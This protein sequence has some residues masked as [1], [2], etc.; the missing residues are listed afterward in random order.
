M[1]EKGTDGDWYIV[2]E[3]ECDGEDSLEELFE[4][5]TDSDVS[6]LLDDSEQK[7]GN[8]LQL[9]QQQEAAAS[10]QLDT[11]LKRKYLGTPEQE[12]D[13]ANLS[14]RLSAVEISPKGSAAKKRLFGPLNDSGIDTPDEA[15]CASGSQVEPP[16]ADVRE[17]L[18]SSNRVAA[19]LCKF[20]GLLDCSFK[21]L[22]RSYQSSKT[23]GTNWVIFV[24][25]PYPSQVEGAKKIVG[26]M[27]NFMLFYDVSYAVLL[28]CEFKKQKC[29]N[30]IVGQFKTIFGCHELSMLCD[31]PR[32]SVPAALFFF[33]LTFGYKNCYTC[34][35]TPEWITQRTLVNQQINSEKPFNLAEMIQ[36]A[37]DNGYTDES[38]V[39]YN[40]ASLAETDSNAMAF[41]QSN[42]QA[43]HV[44]DCVY[45]VRQYLRAEMNAATMSEWV[46]KRCNKAQGGDW[47]EIVRYLKFQGVSILRFEEALKYF[48]KGYPKKSCLVL[49]GPSDTGKSY[50]ATSLN[51]FLGGKILSFY[52]S[53]SHFWLSP[54]SEAKC[55]LLDDATHQAWVFIDTYM[56]SALDGSQISIDC[57][58]KAP[59]QIKCPPLLITT[60]CDLSE[61]DKFRF[62]RSRLT[63]FDFNE[64][65]PF[66]ADGNPAFNLNSENWSAYFKRFW[67]SLDLSDQE[68]E[69]EDAESANTFRPSGK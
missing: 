58:N 66:D 22:T 30:T 21:D 53:Q 12:K 43:R 67:Y 37:Y 47:R 51:T 36:W 34:G 14:P 23:M 16:R 1:A 8:S 24:Y 29:R 4:G 60:N 19:L 56:R 11:I 35:E 68:D 62:L 10:E 26:D 69:G 48:L 41:V 5:D 45:M 55:A 32:L 2:R 15:P 6:G 65:L 13:L 42:G 40:Y 64:I 57:K 54:L 7:E 17:I 46:H 61:E 20:K 18:K 38:L 33:K 63:I 49:A 28:L 25:G 44:K 27:C 9:Y 50:F 52:N 39:A 59:I 31:P 3:A